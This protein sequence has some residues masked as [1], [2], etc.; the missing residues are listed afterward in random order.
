MG[1]SGG[2]RPDFGGAAGGSGGVGGGL[3]HGGGDAS[4]DCSSLRERT[5]LAS[6]RPTVVSTLSPDEVLLLELTD[7]GAPVRAVTSSGETAGTVMP[8]SLA[9]L[10]DCMQSGHT[11]EA[12]VLAIDGG[13]CMVEIQPRIS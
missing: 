4:P 12:R 8:S 2:G 7:G 5:M 1:G 3:P 10:I 6:P 11:F 9:D 13:A